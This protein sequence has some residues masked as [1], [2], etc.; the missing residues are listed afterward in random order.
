GPEEE[1]KAYSSCHFGGWFTRVLLALLLGLLLA[2]SP[3]RGS[4]GDYVVQG[5]NGHAVPAMPTTSG[6]PGMPAA[7][8][9]RP[10]QPA[11][12]PVPCSGTLCSR[13]PLVPLVPVMTITTTG[14]EWGCFSIP[15]LSNNWD[16]SAFL[17]R[18]DSAAPIRRSR[19]I[20]HPP[21]PYC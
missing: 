12:V 15:I 18:T 14:T 8:H 11:D 6:A 1:M 9:L 19:A 20:Y 3:A 16:R 10:R 13:G 21:R 17:T 7:S 5:G 2:P 4:C